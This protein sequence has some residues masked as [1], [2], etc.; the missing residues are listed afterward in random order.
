MWKVAYK[1]CKVVCQPLFGN[2][3]MSCAIAYTFINEHSF[4]GIYWHS[5]LQLDLV[6]H[7][8]CAC[9]CMICICNKRRER[10]RV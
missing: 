2:R 9:V 5:D 10:E 4:I 1:N 7:E 3:T 8:L 6:S